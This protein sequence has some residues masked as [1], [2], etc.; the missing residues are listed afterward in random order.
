MDSRD[1]SSTARSLCV[2]LGL[3]AA[4]SAGHDLPLPFRSVAG[5]TVDR[6]SAISIRATLGPARERRVG[7]GDEVFTRWCYLAADD[8]SGPLL[9]L[10]SDAS[11]MGTPGKEL[12]V[13]RLRTHASSRDREGCAPL[14]RS[15]TLA[16]PGGL[17]LGL[18]RRAIEKLL[19]TPNRRH[20]DSLR[21]Y[22][23]AREYLRP[24]TAVYDEWNTPERRESCFDAGLP[25]VDAGGTVT[26]L[27]HDGKAVEIRIERYDQAIC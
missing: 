22:F 23:Q 17:R 27:L 15:V 13:I 11:D 19:G 1:I 20:A 24:G 4:Q 6:D 8:S 21:Y 2:T 3:L 14:G 16:T 7:S 12:N 26:V 18:A 5:V 25:Y 10:M 9:E